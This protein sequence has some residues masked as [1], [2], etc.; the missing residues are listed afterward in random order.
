MSGEQQSTP[1][2]PTWLA[3]LLGALAML[4]F[5]L[6]LAQGWWEQAFTRLL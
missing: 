6:M 2:I 3:A 1:K 4:L 5:L